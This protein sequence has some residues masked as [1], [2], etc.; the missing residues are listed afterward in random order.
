MFF[1]CDRSN[2][3]N[4]RF[5]PSATNEGMHRTAAYQAI[6]SFVTHSTADTVGV[7]QNT[8]VTILVRMEQ[9]LNMQVSSIL[10]IYNGAVYERPEL[11]PNR[12]CR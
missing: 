10:D 12:W 5:C 11:E 4:I 2:A 6:I 1:D 3:L 8:A 9:L 7:V